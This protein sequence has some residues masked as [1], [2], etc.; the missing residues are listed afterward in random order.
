MAKIEKIVLFLQG[1]RLFH[2]GADGAKESPASTEHHA[3]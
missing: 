3:S 1:S 2:R